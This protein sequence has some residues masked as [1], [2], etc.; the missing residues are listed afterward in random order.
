MG[1]IPGRLFSY[2]G[3]PSVYRS[4]GEVS[5]LEPLQDKGLGTDTLGI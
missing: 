5:P 2:L 4:G 3:D 1:V